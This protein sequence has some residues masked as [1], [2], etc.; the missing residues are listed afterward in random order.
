MTAA[1]EG[2]EWS[3][4]RPG[5][6]LPPGKTRYLFYRRLSGP[7]GQ[8]E[9]AENLVLAGIRSR[10]VQPVV[11]RYT[12]W[13]TG[14]T[15]ITIL[16]EQ[17]IFIWNVVIPR[18]MSNTAWQIGYLQSVCTIAERNASRGYKSFVSVELKTLFPSQ[19]AA[20]RGEPSPWNYVPHLPQSLDFNAFRLWIMLKRR[21]VFCVLGKTSLQLATFTAIII[22]VF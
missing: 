8:S 16:S 1:L 2:D 7:Q 15:L 19:Q 10:A 3:A 22:P 18:T 17:Y 4:A 12:D 5:R 11:N 14:T 13:A 6:T 9:R 20:L 21:H